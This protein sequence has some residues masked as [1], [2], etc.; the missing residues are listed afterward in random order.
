VIDPRTPADGDAAPGRL[1]RLLDALRRPLLSARFL[2]RAGAARWGRPFARRDASAL[3]DLVAGFTYSQTLLAALRTGLLDALADGS[4]DLAALARATDLTP[5]R[6]ALLAD[7]AAAVGLLRRRRS[8]RYALTLLGAAARIRPGIRA[9]VEHNQLL[10]RDLADPVA[11]LLGDR[12]DTA[13]AAFWPYAA[14]GGAA[15]GAAADPA[16]FERYS[17]LM[18]VSQDL[19]AH[20]V[21]DAVDLS[22]HRRL[23]DVGGGDGAFLRAV[24]PRHPHLELVLVDLPPVAERARRRCAGLAPGAGIECVGADVLREALPAGADVATLVRVLHDH[25]DDVAARILAAV[26]AALPAGGR[27][28]I[29]EPMR[30]ARRA[31]RVG[32]VY[33]A[34]YFRAMGRG[35][36]RS[37]A[38]LGELLGAAGFDG[39]REIETHVPLQTCVLVAERGA[40]PSAPVNIG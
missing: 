20:E 36:A 10:Y 40:D 30:G 1:D 35:R 21:L 39:V 15:D 28:V 37:A 25:D 12:D 7:A 32:D 3:F 22:G 24:A 9:M 31:R 34:W 5:E 18:A 17:A 11:L 13:L 23:L 8:G 26:H 16:P 29:A 14:G 38:R 27:L 33:F 2:E 6:C 4:R 19:V